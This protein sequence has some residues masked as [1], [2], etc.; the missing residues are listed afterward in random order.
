LSSLPKGPKAKAAAS[1][2]K[3]STTPQK[4]NEV[5]SVIDSK[6]QQASQTPNDL[7]LPH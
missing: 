5:E 3:K 7:R 6:I 4:L 2:I 1:P